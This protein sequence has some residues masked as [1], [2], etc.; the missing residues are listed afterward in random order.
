MKEYTRR[1]F[2]RNSDLSFTKPR[3]VTGLG[4][5]TAVKVIAKNGYF[6]YRGADKSLARPWKET[7][8]RDQTYNT[9]PRLT[10]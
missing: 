3:S 1:L 4:L 10:A 5:Q 7:S 6:F 2:L 9:I 8:Y